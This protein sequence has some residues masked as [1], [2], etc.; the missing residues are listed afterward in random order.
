MT[1]DTIAFIGGGNMATSLVGG[2]VANGHPREAIWVT[3]LDPG[4]LEQLQDKFRVNTTGD[5]NLAVRRADTV[6][7]AVKPQVISTVL[8]EIAQSAKETAPLLVSIAAGVRE[9]DILRGLGYDA[10]VVRTMPNTPALLGCGATALYAN[11]FVSAEQRSR[12]ENILHA[13]GITAWVEDESLLDAV[14][15]VS[16]SGPAYYFFLMELMERIGVELG[17]SP[18]TARAL[19]LQT[20]LGAARMANETGDPPETLRRKV[21]SP[22]GTT[23]AALKRLSAGDFEAALS[24]ALEAARDRAVALGEELGGG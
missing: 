21:T 5:N 16:G 4:R 11:A 22:G 1:S 12:A 9:R 8:S 17:L 3:D 6:V 23:E 10:A 20:A 19:V 18:E 14:T 15:A 2:L 24:Q 13:V 7:L